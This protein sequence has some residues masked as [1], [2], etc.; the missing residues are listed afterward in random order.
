MPKKTHH[1]H[2][3][4]P[5]F[6]R[7]VGRIFLL[8]F[9]SHES[10]WALSLFAMLIASMVA[11]SAIHGAFSYW[12]R[13]IYDSFQ[14]YDLPQFRFLMIVF[15]GI[16]AINIIIFM[17]RAYIESLLK[18]FWRRFL[19]HHYISIWLSDVRYYLL[20]LMPGDTDNPDQRLSDD[21]LY[22]TTNTLTLFT[23]IMQEVFTLIVFLGILWQISG[24]LSF[25][26]WGYHIVIPGYL[27]FVA[28]FYAVL[29]TAITKHVM[30][31]LLPLDVEK[32]RREGDLRYALARIR[33]HSESIA[34][35]NGE[36]KEKK[37]TDGFVHNLYLTTRI[38]MRKMLYVNFWINGYMQ[39]SII[40]PMLLMAPRYFGEK[41]TIGILIQ[42]LSVFR[43]VENAFTIIV[44]NYPDIIEWKASLTRLIAFER[45]MHQPLPHK[46][47]VYQSH[48]KP[49]LVIHNLTLTTPAGK[50][51]QH[52]GDKNLAPSASTLIKG[53]SGIGKST[54]LRAL[55]GMWLFGEGTI[56]YPAA[57]FFFLPQKPYLPLGKLKEV[58]TYP[59]EARAFSS[60][61][62]VQVLEDVG[63]AHL[64]TRLEDEAFWPQ[65]LSG[66][67]QQRL[68]FARLLLANPSWIFLDEATSAL[69]EPSEHAL[70]QLIQTRFPK[71]TCISVGHRPTLE[72]FHQDVWLF[73]HNDSHA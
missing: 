42:V 22:I 63:L 38:I 28:F 25:S 41:L 70:Y 73:P 48:E 45:T 27:V 56:D 1:D 31:P 8:Y 18:I 10:R 34:F 4:V 61:L 19:S 26:L 66:G 32:E 43:S 16:A 15:V 49:E 50:K 5:H 13:A 44:Q 24:P 20:Q 37:T 30:K 2:H 54:L 69:D 29:G 39:V 11:Y 72:A 14:A 64:K 67:E 21:L 3:H 12:Q 23:K 58:I 59:Q 33:E 71:A 40:V 51:I 57:R 65:V 62:L 53:P 9:R 52:V 36:A 46:N 6:Y 17:A 7:H 35:L 55:Q 47:I 60:T 68:G